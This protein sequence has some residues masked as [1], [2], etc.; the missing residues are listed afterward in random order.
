MRS[1]LTQC[2]GTPDEIVVLAHQHV[3]ALD[4]GWGRNAAL[5]IRLRFPPISMGPPY[6]VASDLFV[7]NIGSED[8][9]GILDCRWPQQEASG[10]EGVR[11]H[12]DP[13][14]TEARGLRSRRQSSLHRK[15]AVCVSLRAHI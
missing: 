14:D 8:R 10:H 7:L 9:V 11:Q 2:E 4:L 5:K 6:Q 13:C 3:S 12:S 1:A 15:I